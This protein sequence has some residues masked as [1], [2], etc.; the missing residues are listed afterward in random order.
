MRAPL[1]RPLLGLVLLLA[2]TV[3]SMVAQSVPCPPDKALLSSHDPVYS[4]AMELKQRLERNDFVVRCIFPTKFGSVFMTEKNGILQ[5]SV[6]GEAC[7]STNYGGLDVV[8]LPKPQTFSDF[9]IT[10][11]RKDRGYLYRFTG[12]PQVAAEGKF[13][14]GTAARQY[15]LKHDNFLIIV[16]DD[17]LLARLQKAFS[18]LEP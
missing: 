13:N 12:T 18:K 2:A 4:D 10:E 14:F 17:K 16:S 1:I 3:S 8:F 7:F 5:S 11:R 6:E 9:E 15:F